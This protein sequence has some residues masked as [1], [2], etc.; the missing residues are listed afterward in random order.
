MHYLPWFSFNQFHCRLPTFVQRWCFVFEYV[1]CV[2]LTWDNFYK[3]FN[4]LFPNK[5]YTFEILRDESLPY[6]SIGLIPF[7]SSSFAEMNFLITWSAWWTILFVVIALSF[8]CVSIQRKY[9]IK[10]FQFKAAFFFQVESTQ[11]LQVVPSA[12]HQKFS[13]QEQDSQLNSRVIYQ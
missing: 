12:C 5:G 2:L 3:T 1:T 10:T 9:F 13:K 11:K 8:A 4:K 6:V 7:S